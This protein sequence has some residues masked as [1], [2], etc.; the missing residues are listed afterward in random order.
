[1]DGGSDGDAALSEMDE[2]RDEMHMS[3]NADIL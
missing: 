2:V 1:M 3:C